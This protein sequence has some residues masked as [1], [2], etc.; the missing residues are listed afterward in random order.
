MDAQGSND[1]DAPYMQVSSFD[2]L[3]VFVW[4]NQVCIYGL[5]WLARP[6]EHS[7][8]FYAVKGRPFHS[9]QKC[10]VLNSTSLAT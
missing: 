1:F 6:I 9:Q 10:E 5:V 8:G 2:L 3:T 4:E 7:N